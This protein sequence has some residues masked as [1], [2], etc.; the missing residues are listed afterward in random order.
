MI[1]KNIVIAHITR[2]ASNDL[3]YG[4][5]IK[6]SYQKPNISDNVR[7]YFLSIYI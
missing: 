2:S 4:T 7:F 5:K 3:K 6:L 1:S